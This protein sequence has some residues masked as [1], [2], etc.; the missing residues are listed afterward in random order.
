MSTDI[1]SYQAPLGNFFAV[2]A[3][4]LNVRKTEA[5]APRLTRG[6]IS[7]SSARGGHSAPYLLR[8]VT[9]SL[10]CMSLRG[11]CDEVP[12]RRDELRNTLNR[13]IVDPRHGG[14]AASFV[15]HSSQ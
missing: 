1:S 15:P 6:R 5:G 14:V 8:N 7:L 11:A 4:L 2:E 3:L 13:C 9:H 12:P 10:N